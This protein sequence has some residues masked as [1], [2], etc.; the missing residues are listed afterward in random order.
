MICISLPTLQILDFCHLCSLNS[1][2]WL[3]GKLEE[4]VGKSG[5]PFQILRFLCKIHDSWLS[6]TCQ[7]LTHDTVKRASGH[8][9]SEQLMR[10][11]VG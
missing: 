11:F 10:Q 6:D 9:V 3:A 5:E 4:I 2:R 7:M 8:A 1:L